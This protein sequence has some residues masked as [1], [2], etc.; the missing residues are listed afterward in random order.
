MGPST[1]GAARTLQLEW[2]MARESQ[3]TV[4]CTPEKAAGGWHANGPCGALTCSQ[5]AGCSDSPTDR[6]N[7]IGLVFEGLG[8]K[9]TVLVVAV[10]SGIYW[11]VR[12]HSYHTARTHAYARTHART[13]ASTHTHTHTHTRARARAHA[14]TRT[15][16]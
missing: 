2:I 7:R 1:N 15:D 14:S 9:D 11:K 8:A 16:I 13:H 6:S 12:C 5:P 10:E 3:P 4:S